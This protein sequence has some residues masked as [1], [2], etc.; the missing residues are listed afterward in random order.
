MTS[1]RTRKVAKSMPLSHPHECNTPHRRFTSHL[2][3]RLRRG[4][5]PCPPPPPLRRDRPRGPRPYDSRAIL[6]QLAVLP[7]IN[8][9]PQRGEHGD[10][11]RPVPP[12][13]SLRSSHHGGPIFIVAGRPAH[14]QEAA[15][16]CRRFSIFYLARGRRGT[17]V[18]AWAHAWCSCAARVGTPR[19]TEG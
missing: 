3:A 1:M 12:V 17:P 4:R 9:E 13:T 10:Q 6:Q 18:D 2:R 5:P 7:L 14:L 11:S 15:S 8:S 16:G 19:A